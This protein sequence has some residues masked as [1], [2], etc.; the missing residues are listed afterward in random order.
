ML[1]GK[2]LPVVQPCVSGLYFVFAMY[3]LNKNWASVYGVSPTDF[4]SAW[5]GR[6][7]QFAE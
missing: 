5:M 4:G 7:L 3:F 2:T 6:D 1:S